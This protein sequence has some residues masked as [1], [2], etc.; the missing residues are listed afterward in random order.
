MGL[1]SVLGVGVRGL[2]ASQLGM[3]ITGQNIANADVEGYS[4]KRLNM[5]ADYRWHEAYGQMGFGVE[6]V[7][8]ER[9]RNELI[10]QQIRKQNHKVGTYEEIDHT[11]E[12]IENIFTE[13][14]DT[15]LMN[16]IDQFFNSWENLASNPADIASR[17]MVK[18]NAEILVNVFHNV[19]GELRDLRNTRNDEV[20]N[21]VENI[22][23]ITGELYNLNKEIAT[24]EIGGQNANDS[25]DRR[26]F[27]LKNLS[28]L[29]EISVI[30]NTTGQI[31]VTTGGNILVSPVNSVNLEITSSSF[32][33]SDGTSYSSI[34]VRFE[35]SHRS[36]TPTGGELK[37]LFDSRDIHI[38]EYEAKLDEL[39]IGL[40]QKINTQH[41]A[42]YNLMGYSGIN[43]FDPQTTGASNINLSASIISNVRNIAAAQAQD[44]QIA[45]TNIFAAGDLDFG[46]IVQ[47]TKTGVPSTGPADP[48]NARNIVQSTPV[49]S[50]AGT[51]LVENT[52]YHIDYISGTIQMLHNGNNGNAVSVDF[53]YN[54]GDW[55]GPGDNT[56]AVS[57]SQLRHNMTMEVDPL[58]TPTATFDQFY[59]SFIGKLGLARNEAA[60][61][62]ETR[63]Y[64]VEQYETHQD[65]IAGVSLDEEMA[66]L[67]KFQHTYQAAARVISI[68]NI[69][70]DTLINL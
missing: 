56:N 28:N 14:S 33:R 22:N 18:T 65:S 26:D 50:I 35:G 12:A 3:D 13:P 63:K 69:M 40:A 11:L 7:N 39:A 29:I 30:E 21:R 49:V 47:L 61:N 42:G 53:D 25:K 10:D 32:T 46:N 36:F 67:I 70:L 23:L 57:I 20:S 68:A 15:G 41:V 4:R 60:S 8:I 17:T 31:T 51:V 43:F 16:Y 48:N 2:T 24:I 45:N 52:D 5:T 37:G 1:F 66:E 44:T 55:A 6:V 58:G 59:G 34:G 62:L 19:S 9:V 38:P 27:L 64:L 54:T